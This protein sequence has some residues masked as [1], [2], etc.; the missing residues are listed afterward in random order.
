MHVDQPLCL[1]LSPRILGS[2]STRLHRACL[3]AAAMTALTRSLAGGPNTARP[4]RDT[5]M[6]VGTAGAAATDL[7][8]RHIF[9]NYYFLLSDWLKK[10]ATFIGCVWKLE[11]PAAMQTFRVW[12]AVS[13][14]M[15]EYLATDNDSALWIEIFICV[16]SCYKSSVHCE[17][18]HIAHTFLFLLP[19]HEMSRAAFLILPVH[20][21]I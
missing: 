16:Y 6:G 14:P 7:P 15:M 13:D 21:D 3:A 8:R 17:L 9:I 18:S 4:Q 10:P 11:P 2:R 5:P 20:G 19:D 1:S 12:T